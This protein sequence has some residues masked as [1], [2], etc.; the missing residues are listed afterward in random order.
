MKG[1]RCLGVA[2]ALLLTLG[3]WA[4][5]ASAVMAEVTWDKEPAAWAIEQMEDLASGGIL[6]Q[7][8][9]DPTV[10]VSRGQFCYFMVNIIHREGRRDLLSAA[11]PVAVDYFDDITS[12]DG[13]GGRYNM[14]TAAAYGLTEGALVNDKR[15]ADCDNNLTREQ[16]AKMMCALVDALE[17]YTGAK[18]DPV[19]PPRV[20]ADADDISAWAREAV[21]R[22]SALGL[23]KG[24][25]AGRFAPK[26][27]LTFQE[28]CVM[29]DRAF[30]AAEE[31]A[32]R[33]EETL[34][35]GH[36]E[37]K[38][39]VE[40]EWAVNTSGELYLLEQD[41]AYSVL[42]IKGRGA[43]APA[44]RVERFDENGHS[45][46]I[47]DIPMELSY[48]AGFYDGEDAYYLAF[49]QD[50]MEEDDGKE[51]YRVVRYDREW[52]RVAAASVNGGESYTT[53]PY[54]STSHVA[55]AED[56]GVLI[57]HTSRLRYLTP[58]DGLRHQSNITIKVR[59]SDM[60]VVSVS[61][62]FPGNHV[63]HSFAQYV[64]F[65][66]GE[67]VYADHGD[68]YPRGFA[69]NLDAKTGNGKEMNFFPFSGEIG[70]NTTNAIPGG[71]G[72]SGDNYLFA[73]A[74]SPQK[75]N[76]SLEYANAFL[77]VI[78]KDGYPNSR[79]KIKWLTD[80]SANGEE[81]VRQ[82]NMVQ[83]NNN[84]FVVMWQTSVKSSRTMIGDFGD[85]YYAVFD[86]NGDQIG[87]N[88]KLADF[89]IPNVDPVVEGGSIRWVRP[90][91]GPYGVFGYHP[92]RHLKVY[93]LKVAPNSSTAET[94]KPT[95]TP[96]PTVSPKPTVVPRPAE[97]PKPTEAP[98][99]AETSGPS[100]TP[101]PTQPGVT[102]TELPADGRTDNYRLDWGDG[103]WMELQISDGKTVRLSGCMPE[104]PDYY[105]YVVLQ[106][107]GEQAETPLVLGEE[108]SVEVVID[109]ERFLK[110][111]KE[112]DI[113]YVTAMVCQ[114]HRPGSS[115]LAGFSF[116][117]AR[118]QLVSNGS[119]GCT[120]EIIER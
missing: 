45:A 51:V 69:L 27:V 58:K 115:N 57:L 7:G 119:G 20:F 12:K 79:P 36:L 15:L 85:F 42:Q 92:S 66:G 17:R 98:W 109:T 55:M 24:D 47:R 11:D 102:K 32:L 95:P 94:P 28:A 2:L 117:G 16:A 9:Y 72:I 43:E 35:I 34:N 52:N 116:N 25:E 40:T 103:Q 68:A 26:G 111:Y 3:T 104:L 50:N 14:Y 37:S 118:I 80:F 77:A 113:F 82:I 67:A 56:G 23:L 22:A 96:K 29:L 60:S 75:G 81:Y 46:G 105:N 88:T 4:A 44:V 108:F 10:I 99:P 101:K 53:Q 19:E 39:G 64:A 78:P 71:L 73:G 48:C 8:G 83:L 87:R 74:S 93:E 63:S 31:A 54:R 49:G 61:P 1:K 120:F 84:T 30:R 65:D 90:E 107:Y 6:G 59:T 91:A 33:R 110:N 41:G 62:P 70:D 18:M 114:N 5:P 89:M 100:A 86:G 38:L 21:D 13:F 76:D 112:G 97:T 106:A